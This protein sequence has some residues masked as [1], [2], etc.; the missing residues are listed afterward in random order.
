MRQRILFLFLI[1][2]WLFSACTKEDEIFTTTVNKAFD[3]QSVSAMALYNL[4][5]IHYTT[6]QGGK[7]HSKNCFTRIADTIANTVNDKMTVNSVDCPF[8]RKEVTTGSYYSSYQ[9]PLQIIEDTVVIHLNEFYTNGMKITGDIHYILFS[10]NTIYAFTDNLKIADRYGNTQLN[11]KLFIERGNKENSIYGTVN[12]SGAT[13]F[14]W[15]ISDR[16][17]GWNDFNFSSSSTTTNL[18]F[19]RGTAFLEC[20][21]S[22]FQMRFGNGEDDDL[23][24]VEE[25]NAGRRIFRQPAF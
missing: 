24:T 21:G 5:N 20:N 8:I 10:G 1:C 4:V 23:V 22:S 25:F 3:S 7:Y 6:L 13:N 11:A 18:G 12:G 9:F 2:I 14:K 17:I 15:T 16:L 19:R